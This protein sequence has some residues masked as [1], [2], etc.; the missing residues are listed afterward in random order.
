MFHSIIKLILIYGLRFLADL[1]W[2]S[3][4]KG[5]YSFK[6]SNPPL[7]EFQERLHAICTWFG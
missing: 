5:T 6:M 7:Y 3:P 2:P 4:K 1:A